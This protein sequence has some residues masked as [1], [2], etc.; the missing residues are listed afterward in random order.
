MQVN[1]LRI[2]IKD[3][4]KGISQK[5]RERIFHPFFTTKPQGIGIGL[6]LSHK[7][8]TAHGG[9]IQFSSNGREQFLKFVYHSKGWFVLKC[10]EGDKVNLCIFVSR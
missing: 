1:G 4:G 5:E 7:I 6:S 8:I 10:R 2:I 3:T 9:N